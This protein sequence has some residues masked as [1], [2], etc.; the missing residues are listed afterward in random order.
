MVATR[1]HEALTFR[2]MGTDAHVVVVGGQPGL[3]DRAAQRLASLEERWSRF[4]PG[5]EISR[6]NA[7]AGR[8]V[9]V[10]S[11]TFDLILRAVQAWDRSG[12]AFDPTVLPALTAA[13]YDRDYQEIEPERDDRA[14]PPPCPPG[15]CAVHLDPV[16]GA[17]R[18]EQ[19]VELDLGGIAKGVA[20]DLVAT[21]LMETSAQ[22]TCVNLGGDLCIMGA[23]PSSEAWLIEIEPEP[24]I[25]TGAG[26]RVLA[27]TAGGV[28]TTSCRRR[29]WRRNGQERHHVI[30]PR[31]GRP[32][33]SPWSSVTVVASSVGDAE[34]AATAAFLADDTESA[35]RVIR[36]FDAR[37]FA[38]DELGHA[39]ELGDMSPLLGAAV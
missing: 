16:V 27:L 13:G 32:A 36:A 1:S 7:A 11:L 8:P 38:F 14:A 17:V 18:L 33:R 10:S 24:G 3:C 28:A 39:C 30:D 19:G 2:V 35:A 15:A 5:S 21:E 4:R 31:T 26:A 37:G 6:L 9:V 25:P 20:A 29:R 12:G 23:P 22:G 34:P